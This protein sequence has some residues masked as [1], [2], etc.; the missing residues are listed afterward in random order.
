MD[1]P[2][3][4]LLRDDG[5]NM[6]VR[7]FLMLYGGSLG[8]TVG[9]MRNHLASTGFEGCWPAWV[10]TE[11]PMAHLTKGG[12]QDWLRHMFALEVPLRSKVPTTLDQLVAFLGSHFQLSDTT[13]QDK[14]DWRYVLTLTDLQSAF[15]AAGLAP[16]R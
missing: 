9:Q 1:H 4:D 16:V 11:N 5:E 6:A 3:R 2:P 15:N 7:C 10:Y 12:A 14:A 13:A 8:C